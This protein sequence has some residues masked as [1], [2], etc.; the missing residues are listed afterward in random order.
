MKDLRESKVVIKEK[1]K[2]DII[3]FFFLYRRVFII[4]FVAFIVANI[5]FNPVVTATIISN[6]MNDFFGTFIKNINL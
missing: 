3:N 4:I 2:F 6:W 1:N 5:F